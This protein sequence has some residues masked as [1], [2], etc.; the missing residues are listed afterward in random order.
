MKKLVYSLLLV[1]AAVFTS[2]HE[3]TTEDTSY[4][5]YYVTFDLDGGST[6]IHPVGTEFV[7]PGYTAMEGTE[8]VTANVVV[9]GSVDSDVMGVYTL[10]YS[11]VNSDGYSASTSRTVVVYDENY[12]GP[13][14]ATGTYTL[15]AGSSRDYFDDD[16]TIT[17][18]PF[19]GYTVTI[20][21][22]APGFFYCSDYLGGYY[23]QRAAY[24]SSY[25]MKG[26]FTID[27]D[28]TTIIPI[29]SY[30]SGWGDS[31]DAMNNSKYD[32]AAQTLYWEVDYAYCMTFYISLKL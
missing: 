3:V 29:S 5:T 17:N 26:Y 9:S 4:I 22:T 11:A 8:D 16:G 19:D 2:C 24:G 25:A 28:N 14:V 30:V 13:D 10:T 32:D 31:M 15:Q 6:Y 1:V 12:A 23:D 20:S 21:K 7:D 18:T 27:S